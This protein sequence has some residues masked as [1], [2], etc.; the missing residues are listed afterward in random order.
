MACDIMENGYQKIHIYIT[1]IWIY[2]N[3]KG[4][5]NEKATCN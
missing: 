4:A 1:L 5:D 3:L 2:L